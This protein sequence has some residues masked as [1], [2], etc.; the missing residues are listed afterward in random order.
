MIRATIIGS[1]PAGLSLAYFL[2][3]RNLACTIISADAAPGGLARPVE[4][5]G[6]SV[7][8]GPHSFY[9]SYDEQ[10]FALLRACFREDELHTF[11]PERAI[12]TNAFTVHAPLH[13]RDVLQPRLVADAAVMLLQRRST[14]TDGALPSLSARERALSAR[15]QRFLDVLFDPW[16]RKQFGTGPEEL[17]PSLVDLLAAERR[18]GNDGRIVHPR[19]GA[20][21]ELWVRLAKKLLDRGVVFRWCTPVQNV[22]MHNGRV[23]GVVVN[24]AKEPVDGPLFSSAPLHVTA[25][26]LRKNTSTAPV[27]STILVFMLVERYRTQALYVTDYR[28]DEPIGRITFAD[29]WRYKA[30][31]SG[32]RVVCAEFWCSPGD[33]IH[34]LSYDDLV[35]H[36]RR[37]LN[38]TGLA[39]TM[40]QA[41]CKIIGPLVTTPVPLLRGASP[42]AEIR[43]TVE[44]VNGLHVLGRHAGHRWDGVDDGIREAYEL[45]RTHAQA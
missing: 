42:R 37:Y 28:L 45:A 20:I 32:P 43:A 21:G 17:D 29:N 9:A 5:A 38:T 39:V 19:A 41:E 23:T 6:R 33:H 40:Q 18:T 12:R 35:D 3:E 8:L 16:C 7:D 44:A 34:D 25:S 15:G 31:D 22:V 11:V 1:G 14:P 4:F 13:V 2:S 27:R 24:G 10:A 30:P 26:W 36:V